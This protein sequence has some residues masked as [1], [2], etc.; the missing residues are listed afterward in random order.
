MKICHTLQPDSG[1]IHQKKIRPS[2][3]PESMT[4]SSGTGN[5]CVAPSWM[6]TG[7]DPTAFEIKS[8]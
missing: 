6:I 4:N 1:Q 5:H 7:P 3:M 8:L 2:M